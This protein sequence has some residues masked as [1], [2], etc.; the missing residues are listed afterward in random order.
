M[1]DSSINPHIPQEDEKIRA[2]TQTLSSPLARVV[3]L[4]MIIT[5]AI[6]VLV[7]IALAV[8][9]PRT[10]ADDET[11]RRDLAKTLQPTAQLAK[12]VPVESTHGF[13]LKYDNHLF[14]SYAE[15]TP[16]VDASGKELTSSYYENDE[17]RTPRDYVS[18]RITPAESSDSDRSAVTDPPQLVVSSLSPKLLTDNAEKPDYKGLSQLAL[19]VKISTDQRQAAK[20]ADDGTTVSIDASKPSS[21]TINDVKYQRVRFTTR[22]ENYRIVNVKYDDCYYT[23]QNGIPYSAC[24]SNVRPNSRNDAALGEQAMQSLRFKKPEV[25]TAKADTEDAT[26]TTS[27]ADKKAGVPAKTTDAAGKDKTDSV[28]APV[29]TEKDPLAFETPTPRYYS[30]VDELRAVARNQPS[31]VRIGTLYCADLNLKVASGEVITTLTDACVG[32]LSSGTLVSKDGYIATTGRAVQF[33]P[34]AAINGYI[35]FADSQK[36]LLNRLDR[37]LKYLLDARLILESDAEYLKTGAQ[38]GDQEALAK[39]E[40]ISSIIPDNY[41]TPT[42]DAYSY[43]IQPTSKPLVVDASTGA[44][45]SFAYSDTVIPAKFVKAKYEVDK[46]LQTTFDAKPPKNDVGLLKADGSFQHVLIGKGSIVKT[47]DQLNVMGYQTF[48]DSSLAIAKNQN[49][50]GIMTS[51]VNQTYKNED[52]Q[53][54]QTNDPIIPGTDG[55]GVFD[56]SGKLVGFGIYGLLYCPDQYC[57]GNGTIRPSD[58]LMSL[59]DANNI[60]L[61]QSS[62]ATKQWNDGVAAYLKADYASAQQLFAK[63]GTQYRFNEFATP[64]A[65][66]AASKKGSAADTSL[67]NQLVGVLIAVLVIAVIVTVG[68]TV[69][70][71]VQKRRL[72]YLRVGHYGVAPAPSVVTTPPSAP[73]Y[74]APQ[75]QT[76]NTPPPVQQLPQSPVVQPQQPSLAPQS[77]QQQPPV[78]SVTPPSPQQPYQQPSAIPPSAPPAAQTPHEDPFYR[79]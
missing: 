47:N 2:A 28:S 16:P 31:V 13:M 78:Q 19:F 18:V 11:G 67:M 44:R 79:Q 64:L 43:A 9:I 6:V 20:T 58:E 5:G 73:I 10:S 32:R 30:N 45:P 56:A 34:K 39:I 54:I 24:I 68:S 74:A 66:L 7:V 59:L 76:T 22:N 8:I 63:A 37:V 42:K 14:V 48:S 60:S 15:T 53:L 52:M 71:L 77:Y 61:N 57:L 41:V 4:L 12:L 1:Q 21:Q 51:S 72:D 25:I 29:V 35:N 50:P 46:S 75:P 17:L 23:I 55:G 62:E 27:G 3:K 33:S 40:N 65:K 49:A 36:D 69:L 38:T 26:G 70:F